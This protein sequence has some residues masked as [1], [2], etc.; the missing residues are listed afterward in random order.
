M[1]PRRSNQPSVDF[2][3]S[4][5]VQPSVDVSKVTAPVIKIAAGIVGLV[6]LVAAAVGGY[7]A[8]INKMDRFEFQQNQQTKTLESLATSIKIIAENAITAPQLNAA[9]MQMQ[10]ANQRRGWVCP[11]SGV[12]AQADQEPSRAPSTVKTKPKEWSLFGQ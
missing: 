11:L 7:Y 5:R 4:L 3:P 6:F 1:A 9:C 8:L 2:H 10:I 12:T